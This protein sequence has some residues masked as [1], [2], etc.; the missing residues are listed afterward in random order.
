MR[1]SRSTHGS[2]SYSVTIDV[3]ALVPAVRR[4][5]QRR[6]AGRMARGP[7]PPAGRG[8]GAAGAAGHV[9]A[10]AAGPPCRVEQEPPRPRLGTAAEAQQGVTHLRARRRGGAVQ[11]A[12]LLL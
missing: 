12:L 7:R 4:A 2:S 5:G 11:Q 10:A 3:T 1:F 8:P 6:S 9:A